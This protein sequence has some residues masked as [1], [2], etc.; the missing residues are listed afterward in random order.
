MYSPFY[1]EFL[2]SPAAT[3]CALNY[4]SH[5]CA[6]CFANLNRPERRADAAAAMRQIGNVWRSDNIESRL[7][8]SGAPILFSNLVDPFATVNHRL[9][10]PM[11]TLLSEMG[12]PIMIQTRGGFGV[13][14]AM[15]AL[16]RSVWYVSIAFKDEDLR[17]RLEPGAPS[18]ES[19]FELIRDL[20][21]AGH[22]VMVGMLPL[23]HGWEPE[24]EAIV[25]RASQC[26]AVGVWVGRYHLSVN[27]I[28]NLSPRERQELE[29]S[30][31]DARTKRHPEWYNALLDRIQGE[32]RL[33]DMFV[34]S[35]SASITSTRGGYAS[36]MRD[37]YPHA[38]PM[39]DE[40]TEW[41]ENNPHEWYTFDDFMAVLYP[42]LADVDTHPFN[43]TGYIRSVT[44]GN[45][46]EGQSTD[47]SNFGYFRDL[48]REVWNGTNMKNGPYGHPNFS[49]LVEDDEDGKEYTRICDD[50]G[51]DLFIH[52]AGVTME[53]TIDY[54]LTDIDNLV[55]EEYEH[56]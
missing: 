8:R 37:V 2:I 14:E 13:A 17:R 20:T 27:Q 40:F 25:E 46:Y 54:R 36:V 12:F 35:G 43:Y 47:R 23:Y 10:I 53:P 38:F 4:C 52:R 34:K 39:F 6:F 45:W 24:P 22:V 51:N 15:K 42:H 44:V 1:G 26:G 9:S 32:A 28:K 19:R 33:R 30:L 50:D 31:K 48:M 7:M 11:M 56:A 29:P 41:C 18:I 55:N 16:P 5:K 3:Q 21:D 49:A